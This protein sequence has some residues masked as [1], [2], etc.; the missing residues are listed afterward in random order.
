MRT[1]A[2][3][4]FEAVGAASAELAA[5]WMPAMQR[6]Q[7]VTADL[8]RRKAGP[9]R[10]AEGLPDLFV[11]VVGWIVLHALMEAEFSA[12]LPAGWYGACGAWI[13]RGH[14]PC[15]WEGAWPDGRLVVL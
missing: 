7:P 9:T 2:S 11:T 3:Q 4:M 14:F 8:I 1:T 10:D 5:E 15:G 12:V 6:L 13:L